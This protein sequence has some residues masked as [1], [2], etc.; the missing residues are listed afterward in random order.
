MEGPNLGEIVL[1]ELL[2]SESSFNRIAVPRI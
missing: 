1:T 2:P